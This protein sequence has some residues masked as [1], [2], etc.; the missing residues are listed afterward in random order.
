MRNVWILAQREYRQY[1][2]SPIAYA[3]AF[4]F[5]LVLGWF[6]NQ[7]LANAI[8]FASAQTTTPDVQL[9]LGPMVTLLLFTMP[10]ITMRLLS[11]EMRMGT[12]ELLLTAP[13]RDWELVTGKWLGGF[14]FISTLIL[15][16]WVYPIILNQIVDP[17]IDQGLFLSGYLGVFLMAASLVAMGV[18][19]SSMFSHQVAA[20]FANL[21]L[22]LLLWFIQPTSAAASGTS[23][24]VL[25]YLNFLDHY[26]DFF[27][28]IINLTDVV[29]YVSLTILALVIASVVIES[30]RW[31]G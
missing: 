24:E 1:F 7:S 11:E 29:Y 18:A 31:R 20:F 8:V 3:A 28:G 26:L 21:G 14:L 27:Q 9:V 10:A 15:V 12:L 16:T 25:R 23:S 22:V 6:F 2:V 19:I 30:R 13:V 4:L 17:G 5:L